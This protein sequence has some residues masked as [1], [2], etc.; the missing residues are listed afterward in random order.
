MAEEYQVLVWYTLDSSAIS[1]DL[2]FFYGK[3]ETI[4]YFTFLKPLFD[5]CVSYN[6]EVSSSRQPNS[7][8]SFS[9]SFWELAAPDLQAFK[10]F[11][12][13]HPPPQK[14]FGLSDQKL[15]IYMSMCLPR[16]KQS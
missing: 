11:E 8:C 12:V 7:H 1:L 4:Y 14:T 9:F 2:F 3:K 6:P 15:I 10:F 5:W 13:P 16:V